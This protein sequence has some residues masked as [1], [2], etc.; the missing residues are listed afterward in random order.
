MPAAR[1]PRPRPARHARREGAAHDRTALVRRVLIGLFFANL[2]VVAAKVA[3]GLSARSLAV[4][5]DALHSSVDAL[6]NILALVVVRV[7]AQA[8][9]EDHPYGHEK[10]ETLGALAIVGFLSITCFELA[11]DAVTRLLGPHTV[12]R[13]TGAQLL[14]LVGGLGINALVAWYEHRRG[15]ELQSELLV[16][17]AAHTRS[18]VYITAG[19]IVG[20]LLARRGWWW[21]DPAL[22]LMIAALIVRVAYRII[23][24]TV[25]I[26]VDERALPRGE[27][28]SVAE[29]VDGVRGA[30]D[31]RS[32]GGGQARYAEL[33]IAV[34]PTTNV[35]AAHAI[36]DE[37]EHR[38]KRDLR[39]GAVTVHVEPC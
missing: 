9:D 24:R 28:Q 20:L 22:A 13:V 38:L 12:P 8:P 1:P 23:Q 18:D 14:I 25:P 31:I 21:A 2:A 5:G 39:L 34:D 4:L 6:N 27:I 33:T 35:A 37:V 26:L 16:S 15:E 19:V 30:Y 10:F 3:V 17:D 11:R 32:R 36:A 29:G 7:A